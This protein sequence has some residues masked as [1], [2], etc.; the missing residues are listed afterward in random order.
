MFLVTI[1]F[2]VG[3]T[4]NDVLD[5][6]ETLKD[7]ARKIETCQQAEIRLEAIQQIVN[8]HTRWISKAPPEDFRAFVHLQNEALRESIHRLKDDID[9]LTALIHKHMQAQR[10]RGLPN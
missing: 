1:T 4:Y 10:E 6:S 9:E 8:E 5:N 7:Q 2:W 3:V